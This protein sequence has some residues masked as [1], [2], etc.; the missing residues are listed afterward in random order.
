M[1][2]NI[3]SLIWKLIIIQFKWNELDFNQNSDPDRMAAI[4]MSQFIWVKL[5]FFL[6]FTN[7][8]TSL[9]LN[10]KFYKN[11]SYI[12]GIAKIPVLK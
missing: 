5:R 1:D 9:Y 12:I 6:I 4:A 11:L 8:V 10:Y 7:F 3:F 2:Q